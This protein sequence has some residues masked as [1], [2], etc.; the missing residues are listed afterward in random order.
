MK[1]FKTYILP[2]AFVILLVAI[3]QVS[4]H[5]AA[6]YLQPIRQFHIIEGVFSLLYWEN[7]GMAFG[8]MQGGRWFF[9]VFTVVI[10]GVILWYYRSLPKTRYHNVMRFFL[11]ML[12]GGALGNFIDRLLLGYV[13]DFFFISAI[14]F[15]IFNFADIFLVVSI[16]VLMAI[17]LFVKE[18]KDV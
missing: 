17:T 18:P 12:I 6:V 10:L 7:S 15:P 3:D 16:A 8:V 5:L 13:I 11:L 4:K 9:V 2:A 14:N 1:I